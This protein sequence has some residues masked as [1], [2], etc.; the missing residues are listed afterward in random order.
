MRTT[1]AFD[2]DLLRQLKAEA[3]RQGETLSTLVNDLLRQALIRRAAPSEFRLELA[4]W[5]AETLP[6]VD[7][8]DRDQLFDLMNGR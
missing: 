5:E 7:I 8:M 1:I 3:A 4:G 6:G 2:D